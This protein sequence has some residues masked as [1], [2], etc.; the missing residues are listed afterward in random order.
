MEATMSSEKFSP[1]VAACF[2]VF[3]AL[4]FS[5]SFLLTAHAQVAGATL[6][7]T[8]MDQSG[9]FVPKAGISI[10][11]IATG[12][13]RT[14][15]TSAAGFYSIPN[16]LPGTYQMK[17]AAP[18]FASQ[19]QNDINL[20]VG[21]Q[22]VLNFT[23]Q[24]G[25][26]TQTVEVSAEAPN[27]ELASSSISAVI[28]STTVRELP[29][30]GRSWTDLATLQPGVSAIQ[31]QTDFAV[32]GDRGNRGF[33]NQI[34][35]AGDRPEQN[36]YR[37]DGVSINDFNNAAP[38]SV[39]GGD[40]GVDAV[41]EFSVITSN[42]SAEYGRTSGGVIN[43]ITRSGTNQFHG[44]VYEFIRNDAL[45]AANFFE[46]AGGIK[47]ASFRQNQFGAGV[48][49]PIRKDK[50][51]IFGDYEGIRYSKGI[52]NSISVPSIAVRN[53]L[54]C[55]LCP[56]PKDPNNPQPG[57]Q[58]QLKPNPADPN[59]TDANGV[60]LKVKQYL[61]FWPVST[62]IPAG[63][64]GDTASYTFTAQRVVTENFFTIR[65][66]YKISGKDSLAA[67]YLFDNTPYSSPDGLDAV[68]LNSSTRR[69]IVSLE[70]TH[71]FGP[72]LVN[73]VRGG[74]SREYE[75]NDVGVSAINTLAKDPSLAAIPGQ[76]AAHVTLSGIDQFTGGVDGN[77]TALYGWNSF[78]GYDD[79]FWTHGTHSL[80][81]GGGVERQQLNRLTH[82][83]PSGVFT[84]NTMADF[85]TNNP[86]RFTGED[87]STVRGQGLRQTIFGLYT[88]DDW[89]F[90]PNLTL[91]MGL[92]WEMST[93]IQDY[94]GGIVNLINMTDPLPHCG[95]FVPTSCAPG[96]PLFG[97]ATLHNFEP[98]V[99]FAWDPFRNGKTAVRGS[100]GIFDILPMAYQYIAAATKQF[101]FVSSAA[102]NPGPY[103]FYAGAF[104]QFP[105]LTGDGGNKKGGSFVEQYP[106]RSY[107]M[108]W[109][110][111]VQRELIGNLT[112]MVGYV[113]SR[114]VHEP[115]RT[116]DADIVLPTKTS[117]GYL[118]PQVDVLG[119]VFVPG[120]CNQIDPN[121]SDPSSCNPPSKINPNYGQIHYLTYNGNS[122][123]HA[124]EVAV[125]KRMS[126][127]VQF[128][129]AFTWG[130]SLDTGSAT[131]HGDQFSNSISSLPFYDLGALRARS[132]FDIKRT[133]VFNFTWQVPS[134]T[135]LSGPAAWIANGWELGSIF[136]V[137]DGV[138]F[139]ATWGTGGDPQGLS[140]SDDWAFP[141]RLNTPGCA[142]LVNP[143][144][145]N[146]YI[147]TQCF[148]VPIAP[149]A[150]FWAA[151]CDLAPPSLGG[152]VDP[153]SLQCFNLRGNASRNLLT[154]PG[155]TNLDFSLFKNNPINRISESFNVQ[156]R[157]EFFNVL[158]HAN[159]AVPPIALNHT[160]I[161][162]GTGAPLSTAGVLTSTTTPGREIQFALKFA[163]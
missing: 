145:P 115:F 119:N 47:K 114:G 52:P 106:H 83:D 20:T 143:G 105:P 71:T 79:A 134:P 158:N 19:V 1:K 8:V 117:A 43:A 147:K 22:Q 66:D 9:G 49:G 78:Q 125:Q 51:F 116:D 50:F 88:Q 44:S 12:I 85:L 91:N 141:D 18:G 151:N 70:E 135:S 87:F 33:G 150:P 58:N 130:K 153:S 53:G 11:N 108:Q 128:Q 10:T 65:S 5:P 3:A 31:T 131:G 14:S 75:V 48:G 138:P 24:V 40:L 156:F 74:F 98:R 123:Y 82:T 96:G 95:T 59:G 112:A 62:N 137:S 73:S 32:G 144:N 27:V 139:T 101:P 2:L 46:N 25:Q 55:S 107:I 15:T 110:L 120:V 77:T 35:V 84:F 39:L 94:R 127:G 90:R 86:H 136:K 113:G 72:T 140:N 89:R 161:F 6:S 121:G 160:D 36:N 28:N 97:N 111:N 13:T 102:F 118:Y 57:E 99:G 93:A 54:L 56:P 17:A 37:L 67:T 132:D 163:W 4:A 34:T 81:F 16:L 30:N 103:T 126:R 155:T 129:T 148:T 64:N 152:A 68:L 109:N 122:Y 23:L 162:D 38:G 63:T 76:F 29:L 69:Q 104:P 149:N 154:G 26:T 142:T 146:N 124:L 100:F 133:L 42:V 41:Q 60:D 61:P 45:D 80:K 7:G 159:F 21:E 157:A 92:R